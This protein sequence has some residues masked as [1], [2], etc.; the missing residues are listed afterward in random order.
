MKKWSK[1]GFDSEKI[2]DYYQW[3]N[4]YINMKYEELFGITMR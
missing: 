1:E 2:S 4:N 3:L